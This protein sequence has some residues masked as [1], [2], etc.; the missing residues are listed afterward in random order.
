MKKIG[1]YVYDVPIGIFIFIDKI[2]LSFESPSCPHILWPIWVGPWPGPLPKVKSARPSPTTSS[3]QYGSTNP[4]TL[5]CRDPYHSQID[6]TVVDRTRLSGG[7]LRG[8]KAVRLWISA[9]WGTLWPLNP[10]QRSPISAT[11]SCS[12]CLFTSLRFFLFYIVCIWVPCPLSVERTAFSDSLPLGLSVAEF[13]AAGGGW[14]RLFP[15][16]VALCTPSAR[17]HLRWWHVRFSSPHPQYSDASFSPPFFL[18]WFLLWFK[19]NMRNGWLIEWDF[20][21]AVLL[22]RVRVSTAIWSWMV[23][24]DCL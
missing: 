10:T 7:A 3:Y 14:G 2:S 13:A 16:R 23:P 5:R 6:Q 24:F 21:V 12:G 17:L 15:R 19:R 8:R 18:A 1:K 22:L 20:V 4:A 9:S 11:L